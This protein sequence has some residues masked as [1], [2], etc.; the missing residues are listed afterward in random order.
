MPATCQ[1]GPE[2]ESLH[3]AYS[4]INTVMGKRIC[5]STVD[6]SYGWI[7]AVVYN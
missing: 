1:P 6:D 5:E 4:I 7:I 2:A 3:N